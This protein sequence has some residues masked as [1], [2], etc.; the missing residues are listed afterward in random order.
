M[1]DVFDVPFKSVSADRRESA[2]Q[3]HRLQ[4]VVVWNIFLKAAIEVTAEN[5]LRAVI[6]FIQGVSV[7]GAVYFKAF[8]VLRTK[9]GFSCLLPDCARGQKHLETI[10]SVVGLLLT[11]LWL[12]RPSCDYLVSSLITK[13]QLMTTNEELPFMQK[14]FCLLL[15]SIIRCPT[16]RMSLSSDHIHPNSLK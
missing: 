4:F 3:R 5:E 6:L 10:S 12:H 15:V 8:K 13:N 16:F 9:R 11:L 14:A 2:L 1:S 7:P